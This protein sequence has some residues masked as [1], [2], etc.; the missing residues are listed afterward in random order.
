MFVVA[1]TKSGVGKTCVT[2]GLMEALQRRGLKVQ[3]FKAGPDYIDPGL[4]A[5]VCKVPSYNLDTWMMGASG[6][7]KTFARVMAHG[8]DGGAD[9]G[10]V[11]GV[12]GL[13][14]GRHV[15]GRA[16]VEG[17]TA[18]L[19]K[20]LGL[21]VILVVDASSMAQSV[22]A[23]VE[24]FLSFDR[25]VKFLGVVFNNV[26]SPRHRKII[27]Q[28]V[29]KRRVKV[30]GI[31]AK[32]A[33]LKLPDRHLGLVSREHIADKE[34]RA[35]IRRAGRVMEERLDIDYILKAMGKRKSLK[36]PPVKPVL[37]GTG[38]VIAVA[39]D[40]A[41]SFCYQEN[42]DILEGFGARLA[43][44]SPLKDKKLPK[45]T[46]GIYLIGGYP[47][48]FA[49]ELSKNTKMIDEIKTASKYMP[50]F[51]ECGGL[52]YLG[53]RLKGLDGEIFDMAGVFPWTVKMYTK[54]TALGYCEV[55]ATEGC[56]FLKRGAY[57]LG[58]EYHYSAITG[59]PPARI[60]RSFALND[61]SLE[62]FTLNKTLATYI[63]LHFASNL[64]FARGFV[65]VCRF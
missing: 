25:Q 44:F 12:M 28:A 4:H 53:K 8:T 22:A 58:H 3:P 60:A 51:A 32:D 36:A 15:S 17:S 59:K 63:H 33:G 21:P 49:R 20:T 16:T 38:P 19:A 1:G 11:E 26:A 24:G 10:V 65:R 64:D 9:V 50:I 37:K 52:I 55:R 41:F 42:L 62:G 47:E 40:A 23:L 54:R 48:L 2:L 6:V 61:N 56:P 7:K 39:R 5:S 30:L 14:D 31:I 35:F 43:Y 13:F 18:H 45:G 29:R 46:Q 57:V 34:W 27:E